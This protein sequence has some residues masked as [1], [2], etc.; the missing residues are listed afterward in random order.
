MVCPTV[1]DLKDVA[2]FPVCKVCRDIGMCNQPVYVPPPPPPVQRND[3]PL[4]D[5]HYDLACGCK[6]KSAFGATHMLGMALGHLRI[7]CNKHNDMFDV[8]FPEP[9]K[10]RKRGEV[11]GQSS[12][13]DIPPY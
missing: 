10:R 13:P 9:K 2:C 1:T 6:D 5:K 3:N 4:S 12:F 11:N 8:V 7:Y